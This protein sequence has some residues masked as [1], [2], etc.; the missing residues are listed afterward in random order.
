[1]TLR[2]PAAGLGLLLAA[3][4]QH[5]GKPDAPGPAPLHTAYQV[6]RDILFTPPDWPQALYLDVYRP[7]GPGPFPSVLLIHGGA[8]K[9]GDRAQV[10]GLAER[11]ATRG[12]LVVNTT[13]RLVPGH[14]FPAQLHDVQQALSERELARQVVPDAS[15]YRGVLP[16]RT[17]AGKSNKHLPS[18]ITIYLLQ[19]RCN[20][21]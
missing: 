14:V 16:K 10:E 6:Q 5:I 3:C 9:R 8:W 15:D 17:Y 11:I 21:H 18:S 2:L 20:R 4:S 13:Y 19:K 1:M 12:Y 7:E